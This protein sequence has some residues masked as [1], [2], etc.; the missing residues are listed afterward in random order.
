MEQLI[1]AARDANERIDSYHMILSMSFE[2]EQA[3]R[4]K[5]E[6]LFIDFAGGDISLKDTL[7]DPGT[8]EGTV[9]QEVIRIG[10]KQWRVDP[11]GGGWVEEQPNLDEE[12]VASYK[13]RIS[14]VSANSTSSEVLGEED[15]NGVTATHLRFELS[16][17]NVS[18]LLPDIP[19]SSLEGNAGG[20]VDVWLDAADNYAVKYEMVFRD[21]V[22]QQG[23][24]SVDVHVVLDI[25]GIN[26]PIEI[27]PPV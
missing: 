18:A 21:V 3:G 20:Q 25:T 22:I 14:D 24:N 11:G 16:S 10:D 2:G 15:V 7:Y 4:V 8:G 17:A 12:V 13:P 19:E 23:Y 27:T 26:Q 9:I 5:T 6:E 1:A